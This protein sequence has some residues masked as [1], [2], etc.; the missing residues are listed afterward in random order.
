[1]ICTCVYFDEV[2]VNFGKT[3]IAHDNKYVVN[4]Q[5]FTVFALI[6]SIYYSHLRYATFYLYSFLLF[7]S[8]QC[9]LHEEYFFQ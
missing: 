1:M 7:F 8:L 5:E 3:Q 2:N 9:K 4:Y 6:K